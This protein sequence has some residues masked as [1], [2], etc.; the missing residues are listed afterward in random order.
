MFKNRE[1]VVFNYSMVDSRNGE[2]VTM[3]REH[4]RPENDS[5]LFIL[6]MHDEQDFKNKGYT[7]FSYEG[8]SSKYGTTTIKGD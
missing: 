7:N 6:F 3:Q 4:V 5:G 2:R 8:I 1:R